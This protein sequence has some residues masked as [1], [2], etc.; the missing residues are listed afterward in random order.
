MN[1][2]YPSIK[3]EELI[4]FKPKDP[5]TEDVG[6]TTDIAIGAGTAA[7]GFVEAVSFG[8]LDLDV[9]PESMEQ[10]SPGWATG[11][12]AV[13]SLAGTIGSLIVAEKT[14]GA[15]PLTARLM[16]QAAN[17]S[18]KAGIGARA[19]GGLVRGASIGGTSAVLRETIKQVKEKDHSI[20]R[21]AQEAVSGALLF[22]VTGGAARAAGHLPRTIRSLTGGTSLATA[23]A[24]IRL[25]RGEEVSKEELIES[26]V[27]GAAFE[28]ILSKKID[29]KERE[30]ALKAFTD[31]IESVS[32]KYRSGTT[33]K[34]ELYAWGKKQ[35]I[36]IYGTEN[37]SFTQQITDNMTAM[38]KAA[39]ENDAPATAYQKAL[40]TRIFRY[41]FPET[42]RFKGAKRSA[43]E[44][45]MGKKTIV[46][47][48]EARTIVDDI[49]K[50]VLDKPLDKTLTEK[51]ASYMIRELQGV[52]SQRTA[53]GLNKALPIMQSPGIA[54]AHLTPTK[55]LIHELQ[56]V[57]ILEPMQTGT[58]IATLS[59]RKIRAYMQHLTNTFV[60]NSKGVKKQVARDI[61]KD[62]MM[63]QNKV[64]LNEKQ[65]Y[66]VTQYRKFI[67]Y[68]M[69]LTNAS[70]VYNGLPITKDMTSGQYLRRVYKH[71]TA[72]QKGETITY[73]KG[74]EDLPTSLSF[75][76]G[77]KRTIEHVTAQELLDDPVELIMNGVNYQLRRIF[78]TEPLKTAKA[79]LRSPG[80][81]MEKGAAEF[82][83][84]TINHT[85]IGQPKINDVWINKSL[86][87]IGEIGIVK[88]LASAFKADLGED[89]LG[90]LSRAYKM[91]LN[92]A[93][94]AGRPMQGTRNLMQRFNTLGLYGIKA[95]TKAM[96]GLSSL[97]EATFIKNHRNMKL[98]T[99]TGFE[100]LEPKGYG[101]GAKIE[102][103]AQ[104]PM[105]LSHKSNVY[106]TLSASFH[107]AKDLI[108]NPKYWNPKV[109]KGKKPWADPRRIAGER[110]KF[111]QFFDS[112]LK[113]INSEMGWASNTTQYDYSKSGM[114]ALLQ[115]KAGSA[116]FKFWSWPLNYT[117][118]F[119][120]ELY[121]R[122]MKGHSGWDPAGELYIPTSWKT[123]AL[124]HLAFTSVMIGAAK[125]IGWDLSSI[126]MGINLD[127]DLTK[128]Q[129]LGA[130]A[131][132]L[133][134]VGPLPTS[135]PQLIDMMFAFHT[136][137]TS[138]N[139]Y[140]V[141]R[142]NSTLK[143]YTDP[144]KYLPFSAAAR[145]VARAYKKKDI[146][147]AFFKPLPK[148]KY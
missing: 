119:W 89:P 76:P 26:F 30:V 34:K 61:Y 103:A 6:L 62:A 80:V 41:K 13:G 25:V 99:G 58:D 10:K 57:P 28:A 29:P 139:P 63:G 51:Q 104:A 8:L 129:K 65:Q 134:S 113:L 145:D 138:K 88:K 148:G 144:K 117:F 40:L 68:M 20:P 16:A 114:P 60:N 66:A 127:A 38:A 112:E 11:G 47:S 17:W 82:V 135:G 131:K 81:E 21:M 132:S 23:T 95:N 101:V 93:Y 100:M 128:T 90:T 22:G 85:Y 75:A 46:E 42:S 43:T 124:R 110:P 84:K 126:G 143:Y 125:K 96:L 56:M 109:L 52:V 14:L 19:A 91:T 2:G 115:G 64:P 116:L 86:K 92:R 83:V 53:A 45:R 120:K 50:H 24:A 7:E 59:G 107:A 111:G 3:R 77:E 140:D 98:A 67:D 94:I 4:P 146:K 106:Y 87:S 12:R 105:T 69:S 73:S 137:T 55:R 31:E 142:A 102:K 44:K 1:I 118:N 79:L 141:K 108:M 122:G 121:V 123:G 72:V 147:S 39:T 70:E 5:L 133:A 71:K 15:V 36:E 78:Q 54:S 130:T 33:T 97:E 74:K 32:T 49:Y 48:K 35:S 27:I 37:K 136:A 18:T 9:V